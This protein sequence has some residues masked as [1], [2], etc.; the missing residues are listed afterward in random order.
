MKPR[1]VPQK[2]NYKTNKWKGAIRMMSTALWAVSLIQGYQ[3]II[4]ISYAEMSSETEEHVFQNWCQ[5]WFCLFTSCVTLGTS[6]RGRMIST[7]N[8]EC[9]NVAMAL[10]QIR[11]I[12]RTYDLISFFFFLAV[13]LELR[14]SH[15]LGQVLYHL[16]H[17][18]SPFFWQ[19]LLNYL[20]GLA[21]NCDTPDLCL[22]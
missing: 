13:L 6:G 15:L 16:S 17:S 5:G 9:D 19:D 21:L 18:A 20:P 4:I 11:N 12:T 2:E 7:I 8:H 22:W 10:C 1:E 14:I 3:N